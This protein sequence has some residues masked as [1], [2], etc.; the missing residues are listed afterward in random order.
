MTTVLNSKGQ[1]VDAGDVADELILLR[2]KVKEF[3]KREAAFKN[4]T[5]WYAAG[6]DAMNERDQLRTRIAELE[7]ETKLYDIT[8][9]DFIRSN[10]MPVEFLGKPITHYAAYLIKT[11]REKS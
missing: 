8:A 11:L 3:E 2:I 6:V 1:P 10:D 4:S 7:E 5:P 9:L